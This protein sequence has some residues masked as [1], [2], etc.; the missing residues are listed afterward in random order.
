MPHITEAPQLRLLSSEW[1]IDQIQ[2][3]IPCYLYLGLVGLNCNLY[4][5]SKTFTPCLAWNTSD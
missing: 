1:E 5:H 3:Q 2:G 4:V